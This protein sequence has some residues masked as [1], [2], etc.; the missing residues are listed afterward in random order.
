MTLVK[1]DLEKFWDPGWRG[2]TVAEK[3]ESRKVCGEK[4]PRS[5]GEILLQLTNIYLL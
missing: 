4:S 2:T 1:S 5:M 3:F